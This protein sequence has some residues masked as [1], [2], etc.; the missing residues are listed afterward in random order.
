MLRY[1]ITVAGYSC[2]ITDEKVL[3]YVVVPYVPN[4]RFA[5]YTRSVI[6][7][8]T[9]LWIAGTLRHPFGRYIHTFYYCLGSSTAAAYATFARCPRWLPRWTLVLSPAAFA[10]P[11]TF[12]LRAAAP[13]RA[14]LRL[15]L[16]SQPT[17][18]CTTHAPHPP[19]VPITTHTL[20]YYFLAHHTHLFIYTH[21]LPTPFSAYIVIYPTHTLP[22]DFSFAFV[23]LLLV[24]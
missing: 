5:R 14:R 3:L 16:L 15:R 22:Q 24:G 17:G 18:F 6:S 2:Y 20:I 10:V 9:F 13:F 11:A 23:G 21:A 19:Q 1:Y 12:W 4:C 8:S 7:P